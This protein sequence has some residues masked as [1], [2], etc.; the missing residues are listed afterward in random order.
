VH[1]TADL[2]PDS[3]SI[4]ID[5]E[6]AELRDLF[7]G[8][9]A[10]DR[11]GVVVRSPAGGAGAGLLILAAVIAH[12]DFHGV[13]DWSRPAYPDY[14]VFH[15]GG[16]HGDHG[17]LDIWPAHKEVVV[18]GEPESMLQ[19]INDRAITR[20]AIEDVGAGAAELQA[21]TEASARARLAS[22]FA[23]GAG[24]RVAGADVSIAGTDA[25]ERYVQHVLD[26]CE[27]PA[28]ASRASLLVDGRPT[29]T[30]RR[31]GVDEALRLLA[32]R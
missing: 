24:G 4:T 22:V 18:D 11:L 16:L 20:L 19:A 31:A 3:F 23:F 9:H 15:V 10:H 1:T 26:S 6:S 30:Y 25:T 14:F 27:A 28:D 2:S 12:Y 7:P 8:F 17:M 29:E 32:A 13:P 21:P 5:G